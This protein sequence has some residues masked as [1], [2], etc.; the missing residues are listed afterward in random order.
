[1]KMV[2]AIKEAFTEK[3]LRSLH[4]IIYP[5]LVSRSHQSEAVFVQWFIQV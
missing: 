5:R 1:M 2:S 4:L 3:H